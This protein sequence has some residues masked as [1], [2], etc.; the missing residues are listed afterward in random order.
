MNFQQQVLTEAQSELPKLGSKQDAFGM[1]AYMKDISPFL[2]VRTPARRALGKKIFSQ[3]DDPSSEELGKTAR[4][5]WALPYR[6][7]KYLACDMISRFISEADKRFLS[8]H[9]EF[10]LTKKSWWD[11]VDSLGSAAVS[12]LTLKYPSI[13]LMNRW[14]KS[15]NMWLNRAA[16]QHQRGRKGD[17]DVPLLLKYCDDHSGNHEFFIAKAIGWALRDL[18][19]LDRSTVNRFLQSHPELDRIAVREARKH[20]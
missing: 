7:Y 6:E 10:L 17:T 16:I 18:A 3:L 8:D 2:G 15:S 11:T 4:A 19:R 9:V 14:N 1:Q 20:E 13:A 5:L 12:P